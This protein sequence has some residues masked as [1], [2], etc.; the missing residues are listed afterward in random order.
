MLIRSLEE[1]RKDVIFESILK[2][3]WGSFWGPGWSLLSVKWSKDCSFQHWHPILIG[4]T[5]WSYPSSSKGPQEG[6]NS[7]KKTSK[8]AQG[9]KKHTQIERGSKPFAIFIFGQNQKAHILKTTKKPPRGQ[10]LKDG[11]CRLHIF[12][13]TILRKQK[14]QTQKNMFGLHAFLGQNGIP[15]TRN[16]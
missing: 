5:Q 10:I 15:K 12:K 13:N 14:Q 11:L 2:S 1:A 6:A 3:L 4:K 16:N 7:E 9:A 8:R